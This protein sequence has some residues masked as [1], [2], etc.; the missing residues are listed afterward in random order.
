MVEV[1]LGDAKP[2]EAFLAAALEGGGASVGEDAVRSGFFDAAFGC[3]EGAGGCVGEGIADEEF[4]PTRAV[5]EGG[6]NESCAE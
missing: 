4:V 1:D 3:D 2:T 5:G 6:V